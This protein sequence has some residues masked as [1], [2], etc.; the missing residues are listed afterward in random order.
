MFKALLHYLF[1]CLETFYIKSEND[2]FLSCTLNKP[3][4]KNSSKTDRS[5]IG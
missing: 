1:V 3:L 2:R 5:I 4:G